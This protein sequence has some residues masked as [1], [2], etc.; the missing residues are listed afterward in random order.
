MKNYI[1]NPIKWRLSRKF[2]SI[3]F[4]IL[5]IPLS[6][7]GLL[8]EIE[9]TLSKNIQNNLLL[10]SRII[11]DQLSQNK[12]WFKES[13]LPDSEA[14]VGKELFVFPLNSSFNLDGYFDDWSDFEIHRS[15]FG[16]KNK[17]ISILVGNIERHLVL[18]IKIK[19]ENIVYSSVE[20]KYLADQ[21][22]IEFKDKNDRLHKVFVEPVAA[23][24]VPIKV[25]KNKELK[26]DWRYKGYWLTTDKGANLEIKFPSGIKPYEIRVTHKNVDK[27]NLTHYQQRYSS[28]QFDRNPLI[29]PSTELVNYVTNFKLA[30]AQRIWVL[31]THGRVLASAGNLNTS[32]NSFSSNPIFNWI[33]ASQTNPITDLRAN[34]LRL[35]SKEIYM[36][37][38]GKASAG[39]ENYKNEE[40]SI[41]LAAFPIRAEDEILAV[42][43]IEE[44]IARVQI[45]QKKTLMTMFTIVLVV[46]LLVMWILFWYVAKMVKRI[47]VLN[48]EIE[49][50]VDHK[51][52]MRE[53]LALAIQNGD[54]IDDLYRAFSHMGTRLY[55]YNDHLEK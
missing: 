53:P 1:L 45:L 14:Y 40:Q 20:K 25:E 48:S 28:G 21:I 23:G 37:L 50:V 13:L 30:E 44:N 38:K 52:R 5:L 33:L 35:D 24:S 7:V 17:A 46:F 26:I 32:V 31:D 2:T 19:D 3:I 42:L 8:K 54:E 4:L 15:L 49:R 22:L 55:E 9:K 34:N 27:Q 16:D 6:S 36:A 18:S 29:W 47:K 51:G 43:L 41:A 12:Q 11:S 39:I 10:T